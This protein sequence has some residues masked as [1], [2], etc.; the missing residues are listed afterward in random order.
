MHTHPP[1][2]THTHSQVQFSIV[3]SIS[4]Y[5]V[6]TGCS[7]DSKISWALIIYL[8][9]LFILFMNFFLKSYIQKRMGGAGKAGSS[10][11]RSNGNRNMSTATSSN[12]ANVRQR[13]S[14]VS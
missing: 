13:H 3:I 14:T 8:S 9:S 1:I 6:S 7:Y 11:E 5:N 12:E 2:L 10:S 4:A